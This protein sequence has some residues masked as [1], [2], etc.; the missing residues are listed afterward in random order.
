[1]SEG[2]PPLVHFGGPDRPPRY[3]RQL[4]RDRIDQQP[5]G[6]QI[7]WATYYFRDRDLADC[8][9]AAHDRGVRVTLH[10]EGRPRRKSVNDAVIARLRAHGLGGGLHVHEPAPLLPRGIHPHLHSKIYAFSHPRPS[11]LVGSFNPSGDVPEDVD[12]IAEIGDQDRGHNILVELYE[13]GLVRAL[14]DHVRSLDKRALR[15][16]PLQNQ[17][18]V[19][20]SATAW[21]Y[22]RLC[23]NVIDRG[24][25]GLGDGDRVRGAISHLKAGPLTAALISGARAG[26]SIRLIVHDTVRRVPEAIITELSDAGVDIARYA[27]AE[28][29]PLHAKFLIVA[30][31][32]K[33]A[34][35][36]GSF[37]HNSRSRWLNHEILLASEHPAVVTSLARRFDEIAA[38]VALQK[39]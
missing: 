10:V 7:I 35:W 25:A 18:V 31:K 17:P 5:A 32:T 38:E 24:L 4:L 8:L 2:D 37:N 13:P 36:F 11:V 19:G 39:V 6:A 1:M 14:G 12:V 33:K 26:A 22:P 23:P 21:F 15:L 30:R 29:F 16:C 34:A 3:L 27:H 20:E 9:I 28:G